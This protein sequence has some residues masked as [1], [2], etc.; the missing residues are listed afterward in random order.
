MSKDLYNTLNVSKDANA[1]EIKK[2]YKKLAIKHHPDKGGDEEEFKKIS[3]AYAVLSDEKKRKQYDTFGT[4]DDSSGAMPD[5]NDIFS[6]MF[7]GAG[8]GMASSFGE[9]FFGG[10]GGAQRE[11]NKIKK[12]PQKEIKLS[13]SFEEAYNGSEISYRLHRKIWDK[14]VVCVNCNGKG[15]Q[16]QMIQL[17]PGMISQSIRPCERCMGTGETFDERFA[18]TVTEVVKIPLPKGIPNGNRLALRNQGDKCGDWLPGDVIVAVTYKDHPDYK[19]Y[20]HIPH[21]LERNIKIDLYEFLNGFQK[22]IT[23]L[24]GKTYTI[25]SRGI[26]TRNID[27]APFRVV[28]KMGFQYRKQ[29]GDLIL[30]FDISIPCIIDEEKLIPRSNLLDTSK[31]QNIIDLNQCEFLPS[32]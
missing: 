16:I 19:I 30:K 1:T 8:G 28:K 27:K 6:S 2:A 15:Q 9:M 3:E 5:M 4:Y 32:I 7:G 10:M 17:G 22:D 11:A 12:S 18:K 13:C 24:D 23:H 20:N 25:V 14:G 21:H 29:H 31:S 26:F